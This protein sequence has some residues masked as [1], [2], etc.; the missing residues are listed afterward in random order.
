MK[1]TGLKVLKLVE[2]NPALDFLKN[3]TTSAITSGGIIFDK[4][5]TELR[6]VTFLNPGNTNYY[7]QDTTF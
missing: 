7:K 5:T 4:T 2:T 1:H 3:N 6:K